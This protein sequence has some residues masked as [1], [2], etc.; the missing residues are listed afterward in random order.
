MIESSPGSG[1]N[2]LSRE[3]LAIA[4]MLK[5]EVITAVGN[6]NHLLRAALRQVGFG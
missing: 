1:L 5:A 4:T 3:T 2:L 6:E